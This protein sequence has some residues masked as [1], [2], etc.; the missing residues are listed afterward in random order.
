MKIAV[1]GFGSIGG[2][3]GARLATAG[4]DVSAVARGENLAALQERGLLR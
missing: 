2:L 4:C 1:Y 3:L